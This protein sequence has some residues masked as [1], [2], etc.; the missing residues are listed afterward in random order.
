MDQY[1]N[2]VKLSAIQRNLNSLGLSL[3]VKLSIVLVAFTHDV[4]VVAAAS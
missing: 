1:N 2:I 3:I 4:D